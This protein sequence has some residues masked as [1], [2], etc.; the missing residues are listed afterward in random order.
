MKRVNETSENYA[1]QLFRT[2]ISHILG[3]L[4]MQ[5]VPS[6]FDHY[7]LRMS[8]SDKIFKFISRKWHYIFCLFWQCL[9]EQKVNSECVRSIFIIFIETSSFEWRTLGYV[10][11]RRM[12]CIK[13]SDFTE[14]CDVLVLVCGSFKIYKYKHHGF[15]SKVV[16]ISK[17]HL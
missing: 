6:D 8:F 2:I 11:Q 9:R 17:L 16:H 13:F 10:I 7:A 3:K 5:I 12:T 14:W 1:N 15:I 4:F